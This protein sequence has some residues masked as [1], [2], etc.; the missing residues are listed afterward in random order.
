MA[1]PVTPLALDGAVHYGL[2]GLNAIYRQLYNFTCNKI[3]LANL[4]G[5][6]H[7][8]TLGAILPFHVVNG[9]RSRLAIGCEAILPLLLLKM[10]P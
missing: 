5:L 7:L 9:G 4:E 1:A 6:S 3:Y 10:V 8:A 2:T